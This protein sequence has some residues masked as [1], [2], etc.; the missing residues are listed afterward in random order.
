MDTFTD[1][2]SA[3]ELAY[4]VIS[5]INNDPVMLLELGCSEIEISD[6]T[7]T[8]YVSVVNE[9]T[10]YNKNLVGKEE[11]FFVKLLKNQLRE[12]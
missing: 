5:D 11:E 3:K 6:D 4:Q 9:S 12:R 8:K 10:F 1:I 7:L 2:T